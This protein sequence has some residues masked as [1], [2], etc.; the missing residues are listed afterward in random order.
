MRIKSNFINIILLLS[1]VTQIPGFSNDF[2][3]NV[4]I[5]L[6]AIMYINK[7]NKYVY[8]RRHKSYS[9]VYTGNTCT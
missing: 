3:L 7:L 2:Y 5:C 6:C 4:D 1:R 9:I 8:T